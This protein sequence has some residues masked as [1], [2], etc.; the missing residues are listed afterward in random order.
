MC[1][2]TLPDLFEIE[3]REKEILFKLGWLFK[4]SLNDFSTAVDRSLGYLDKIILPTIMASTKDKSYN[5]F[6]EIIEKYVLYL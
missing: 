6:S 3:E 5:P 4:D 2:R 1:S